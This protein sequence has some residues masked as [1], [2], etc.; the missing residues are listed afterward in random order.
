MTLKQDLQKVRKGRECSR[1][2]ELLV[3]RCRGWSWC[4]WEESLP[5]TEAA[6]TQRQSVFLREETELRQ[7]SAPLLSPQ[8]NTAILSRRNAWDLR[9][10][11]VFSSLDRRS[12][13]LL[14]TVGLWPFQR[15]QQKTL[16]IDSCK[17]LWDG[18]DRIKG[19][20][21]TKRGL[22][23][24]RE[25]PCQQ[26]LP[27]FQSQERVQHCSDQEHPPCNPPS[28]RRLRRQVSR[29]QFPE[30]QKRHSKALEDRCQGHSWW[31]LRGGRKWKREPQAEL[32]QQ[33]SQKCVQRQR[34]S[35]TGWGMVREGG[36][37]PESL[38][39]GKTEL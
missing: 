8:A 31:S 26:N 6:I 20:L 34:S 39:Q 32:R 11:N 1:K 12:L 10:Q 25:R 3:Q 22:P 19:V 29:G 36:G 14:E 16:Y 37:N 18:K 24:H 28:V 21:W 33:T 5:H 27:A 23:E 7:Y 17:K 15:G 38:G 2:R 9:E 13:K 35:L 30:E 4:C